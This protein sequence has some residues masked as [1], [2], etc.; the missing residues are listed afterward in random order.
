[1]QHTD[2]ATSSRAKWE[3]MGAPGATA[4]DR[5]DGIYSE[6]DVKVREPYLP[7]RFQKDTFIDP[8]IPELDEKPKT[9]KSNKKKK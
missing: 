6:N 7:S 2:M 8:V 3:A 9:K 1:M 5:A 4:Q